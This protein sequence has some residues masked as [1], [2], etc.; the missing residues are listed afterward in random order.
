MKHRKGID[1][2]RSDAGHTV[3]EGSARTTPPSTE[4]AY[5]VEVWNDRPDAGGLLEVIA[6]VTDFSVSCAALRAAVRVRPG[7]VLVH[8]NGRHTMST[9]RAP[10]PALPE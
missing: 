2:V 3:G 9:E 8:I 6:R 10:D 1:L 7:K 4:H 5:R